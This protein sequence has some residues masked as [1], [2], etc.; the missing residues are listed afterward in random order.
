M[1]KLVTNGNRVV[2]RGKDA[3][4]MTAKRE[5]APLMN[6]GNDWYLKVP[7]NNSNKILRVDVWTPMSRMSA[8]LGS[9]FEPGDEIT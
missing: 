9:E 8:K 3:T 7:I 2:F 5:A 1:P 6:A 4:L